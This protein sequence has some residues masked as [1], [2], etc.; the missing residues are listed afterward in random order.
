MQVNNFPGCCAGHVLWDF[1]YTDTTEGSGE[2]FDLVE[3]EAQLERYIANF[4]RRAFLI[5]TLNAEQRE[6]YKEM[7]FNHGFRRKGSGYNAPHGTTVY[8]YIRFNQKEVN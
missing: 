5:I 1:G 6:V 4:S 3:Q 7:L 2:D 8:V